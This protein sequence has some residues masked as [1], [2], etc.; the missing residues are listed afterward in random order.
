MS[1]VAFVSFT[2]V[3]L[4]RITRRERLPLRIRSSAH[5]PFADRPGPPRG[6]IRIGHQF[7]A[8]GGDVRNVC[9]HRKLRRSGVGA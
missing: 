3:T 7:E 6:K 4:L 1:A 8:K 2:F 9:L 5:V